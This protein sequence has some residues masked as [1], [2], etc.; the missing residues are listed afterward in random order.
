MLRDAYE[1]NMIFPSLIMIDVGKYYETK[2]S[3]APGITKG[4][5]WNFQSYIS[6]LKFIFL[7]NILVNSTRNTFNERIQDFCLRRIFNNVSHNTQSPYGIRSI[8]YHF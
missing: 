2:Y 7:A 3:I 5:K 4:I 6:S 1:K 8:V